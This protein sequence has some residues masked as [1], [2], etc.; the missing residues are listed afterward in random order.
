MKTKERKQSK[1]KKKKKKKVIF[2]RL[3]RLG[4]EIIIKLK[5]STK[6]YFVYFHK[7]SSEK[8][9]AYLNLFTGND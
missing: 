4:N 1:K 7:E 8:L 2:T 5:L 3:K 6:C 9:K